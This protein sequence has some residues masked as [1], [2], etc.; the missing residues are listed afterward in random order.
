MRISSQ[1]RIQTSIQYITRRFSQE[2]KDW[3]L[4]KGYNEE[5]SSSIISVLKQS[6]INPTTS[7]LSNFGESGIKAL[8]DSI[9][10]KK[11]KDE[12][13]KVSV[14][15]EYPREGISNQI[16]IREGDT[17]HDASSDEEILSKHIEWACGGNAACSTCHV[18]VDDDHYNKF[19]PPEDD[20]LDML[21]YA[22]GACNTSRLGCQL[23]FS[24]KCKGTTLT[25]PDQANNMF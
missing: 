3:L 22:W 4:S 18:I 17:L 14:T 25:I 5:I 6:G 9:Q 7:S 19:S 10:H 2:A 12:K 1:V 11:A 21:D 24:E 13:P 20:E 23:V 8:A 15:V 16:D